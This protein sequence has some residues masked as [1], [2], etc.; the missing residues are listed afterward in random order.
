MGDPVV[1]RSWNIA[2]L[3]SDQVS[4][5]N[6]ILTTKAERH[7]LCIDPQQQANKW[8]KNMEKDS[9][10]LILKFGSDTFLRE[11]TGAVRTGK[12]VLVEDIEENVDPAIDPIL[13]K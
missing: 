8:I 6:G 5:E 2:S 3:P 9:E 13:L 10:M 7:A 11:V 4:T 12:P 1:I